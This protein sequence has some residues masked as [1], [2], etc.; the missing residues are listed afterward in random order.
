MMRFILACT[1]LLAGNLASAQIFE[2]TDANGNKEFAQVCP[3]GTAQQK[4]IG[5][6]A[7]PSSAAPASNAPPTKSLAEQEA[8]F[9]K[10]ALEKK[11]AEAKAA[12]DQEDAKTAES[13]CAD[14]RAQLQALQNGDRM[15]KPGPNGERTYLEDADRPAEIEKAQKSVDSWC[16]KK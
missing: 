5:D 16:N 13:N 1:A 4:Q 15:S 2:C 6:A 10:R 7:T 12:K 8:E 14:A 3:P 11:E 9:R